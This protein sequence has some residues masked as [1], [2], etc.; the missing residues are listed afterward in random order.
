M[1]KT[2]NAFK[3]WVDGDPSLSESIYLRKKKG[4][5]K[6][7]RESSRQLEKEYYYHDTRVDGGE[8]VNSYYYVIP[9]ISWSQV[10]IEAVPITVRQM[11]TISL[12]STTQY[13]YSRTK[14]PR[15]TQKIIFTV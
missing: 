7:S 10:I 12:F 11:P 15:Y 4:E 14:I 3:Y 2:I 6:E 1:Q 9:Q 13:L 5:N 8:N